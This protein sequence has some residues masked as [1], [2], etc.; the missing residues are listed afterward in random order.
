MAEHDTA[1]EK[2]LYVLGTEHSEKFLNGDRTLAS[3]L[4]QNVKLRNKFNGKFADQYRTVRDY[5]LPRKGHVVIQDVSSLVP[6]L[7]ATDIVV[8]KTGEE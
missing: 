1:K 7:V 5:Y 2:Y 6:E 3:V 4:N 8:S